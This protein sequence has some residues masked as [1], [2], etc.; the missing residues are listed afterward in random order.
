MP[1]YPTLSQ[2]PDVN[3]FKEEPIIDPTIRSEMESGDVTTRARFTGVPLKWT[4]RYTQLS[5]ADKLLLATFERSTVN[6]GAASFTWTN[7]QDDAEHEVRLPGQV[8]KTGS[9]HEPSVGKAVQGDLEQVHRHPARHLRA[10]VLFLVFGGRRRRRRGA[11]GA[12]GE[13]PHSGPGR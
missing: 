2:D 10:Q 6:Y 4:Y 13:K 11:R 12:V 5:N 7:P 8:I 1:T 3:G 9:R